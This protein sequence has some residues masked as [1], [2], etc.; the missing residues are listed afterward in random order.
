[1][2]IRVSKGNERIELLRER[3]A[4]GVATIEEIREVQK[5]LAEQEKSYPSIRARIVGLAHVIIFVTISVI[6]SY[7]IKFHF[8]PMIGY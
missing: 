6:L 5:F 8:L 2:N 3:W 7:L 4:S 1:M